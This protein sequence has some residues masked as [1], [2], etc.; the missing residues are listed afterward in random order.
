MNSLFHLLSALRSI[1]FSVLGDIPGVAISHITSSGA[2]CFQDPVLRKEPRAWDVVLCSHHEILNNLCFLSEVQWDDGA[3]A[4]AW[5]RASH[6]VLPPVFQGWALGPGS[7][8]PLSTHCHPPALLLPRCSCFCP[9][10][11]TALTLLPDP[12]SLGVQSREH[13]PLWDRG[14]QLPASRVNKESGSNVL[15]ISGAT[16]QAQPL[17]LCQH[18]LQQALFFCYPFYRRNNRVL[19]RIT[20]PRSAST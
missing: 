18:P 9:P 20:H 2:S 6:A 14:A 11:C 3:R 4:T 5:S 17:V 7:L 19:E 8:T 13:R 15:F 10:S 16:P 1:L 12:K